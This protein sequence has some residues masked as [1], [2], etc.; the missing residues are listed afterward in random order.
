VKRDQSHAVV[1]V[2]AAAVTAAPVSAVVNVTNINTVTIT[3]AADRE[4]EVQPKVV[5]HL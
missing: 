4:S 2:T 5:H 3:V 1:T